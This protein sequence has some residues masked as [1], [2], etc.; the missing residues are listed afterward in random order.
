MSLVGCVVQSRDDNKITYVC[1][2]G[3]NIRI[4]SL[5][6]CT[7]VA[8]NCIV[9]ADDG[10]GGLTFACPDGTS[11]PCV[12]SGST[13]EVEKK[14]I[15]LPARKEIVYTQPPP[16]IEY[17]ILP[18]DKQ[19]VYVQPVAVQQ[20]DVIVA[21]PISQPVIQEELIAQQVA[22]PKVV[23]QQIPLQKGIT[24]QQILLASMPYYTTGTYNQLAPMLKG[25]GNS[26]DC[27]GCRTAYWDAYN[28]SNTV[29]ELYKN[30][31]GMQPTFYP[32]WN[33]SYNK[34]FNQNQLPATS[35]LTNYE[36]FV[37]SARDIAAADRA[38]T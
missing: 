16:E 17:K 21:A 9:T 5:P 22:Q 27:P 34:V 12:C 37:K 4:C 19:I 14:Q 15:T 36:E 38:F 25:I 2:D 13:C 33:N 10:A 6:G 31:Y 30:V 35:S 3:K 26:Y 23:Y 32:E 11:T 20:K 24:D 7:R 29:S 18:Q 8:K 1:G 28:K